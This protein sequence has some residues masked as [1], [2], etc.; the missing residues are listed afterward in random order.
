[1]DHE[2]YDLTNSDEYYEEKS[3]LQFEVSGWFQEAHQTTVVTQNKGFMVNQSFEKS[4]EEVFFKQN[5][6]KEIELYLIKVILLD[7]C[8]KLALFSNSDLVENITKAVNN[9]TVQVNRIS[10]SINHNSTVPRYIQDVWFR[11][12][13]ITNII[14]IKK[15]IKLLLNIQ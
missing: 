15:L 13:S 11:K 3:H 10:L 4:I 12:Y 9:I 8:S 6:T 1:M 5:R 7:N 2:D 14:A